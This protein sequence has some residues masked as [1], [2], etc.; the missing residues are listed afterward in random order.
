MTEHST[1]VVMRSEVAHNAQTKRSNVKLGPNPSSTLL[2]G[3]PNG[4]A[5][6]YSPVGLLR[7]KERLRSAGEKQ[8]DLEDSLT[9]D[10]PWRHG[11]VLEQV[12]IPTVLRIAA[13][14]L[15]LCLS[16]LS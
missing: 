1:L 15:H 13:C 3:I 10:R 7:T 11:P 9:A 16:L 12:Y 2:F 5:W 14:H 4:P 8:A 6:T